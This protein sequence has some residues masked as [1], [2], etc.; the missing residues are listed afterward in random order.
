MKAL[1]AVKVAVKVAASRRSRSAISHPAIPQTH[2][3][4]QLAHQP[5][6]R[7][8]DIMETRSAHVR[9]HQEMAEMAEV[10]VVPVRGEFR[11][12]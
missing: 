9:F 6:D 10:M 8:F 4:L 3:R 7:T 11:R 2:T 1:M 5:S 12:L